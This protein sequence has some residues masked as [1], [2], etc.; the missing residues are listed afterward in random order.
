[1]IILKL[2][3]K[4]LY[5]MNIINI[6]AVNEAELIN[7]YR[8]TFGD[9]ICTIEQIEEV[10]EKCGDNLHEITI[11]SENLSR[12]PKNMGRLNNLRYLHFITKASLDIDNIENC[13][14]LQSLY[15]ESENLTC[16]TNKSFLFKN[17]Q[18]IGL[19]CRGLSN[20][21][22]CIL[23]ENLYT[24]S[25]N[26]MKLESFSEEIITLLV[27]LNNLHINAP[28]KHLGSLRNCRKLCYLNLCGTFLQDVNEVSN[29]P[30]SLISLQLDTNNLLS[31]NI[32]VGHLKNIETLQF[33][34]SNT[35]F[36]PNGI[37]NCKN[38][39]QL[40]L[41][42]ISFL[43]DD[44][45]D[46]N[47][48]ISLTVNGGTMNSLPEWLTHKTQLKGIS[49]AN[50]RL[51]NIPN[52][53]SK[54]TGL[55]GLSIYSNKI[56]DL[57]FV[58]SIPNLKY[59]HAYNN[60]IKDRLFMLDGT[61]IFPGYYSGW[62]E[63]KALHE[64]DIPAFMSAL[65]KSGISREDR[66]WFFYQFSNESKIE[67]PSNWSL[68]RLFQGLTIPHKLLNEKIMKTLLKSEYN[69][70]GLD[71]FKADSICYLDGTFVEKKNTIKDKLESLNIK[72]STTLN[73]I[74]THI[75]IGKKPK[76]ATNVYEVGDMAFLLEHQLYQIIKNI[77]D[78]EKFLVQ[79]EMAG[80]DQMVE[81]VKQLLGSTD[82]NSVH[83]GLQMLKSGGIPS[84]IIE[85]LLLISKTFN[86]SK[87]RAE[88]KKILEVQSPVEW[89]GILKD[90]QTFVDVPTMK[91]KNIRDKFE[92]MT[93][94]IDKR[95]VFL[96]AML[97]SKYYQKGLAFVLANFPLG[98]VER[99]AALKALTVDTHFD[100]H[101]GIGYR[102]W[103]KVSPQEI[104][105]S[106]VN[107]GIPFPIDYPN[108][109]LVRSINM[110]N[111]KFEST[112]KNIDI[113]ENLEELDLSAN[114]LSGVAP[115]LSK[116]TKLKVLDLSSNHLTAFP[117]A[118]A[119][120]TD[121]KKLDLRYNN[122][123]EIQNG[124]RVKITV[125]ENIRE[126]IPTCEILM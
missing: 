81:G 69:S 24:F 37:G 14:G 1:M 66:E 15:F 58:Y 39:K 5:I 36:I 17:L 34:G 97:M 90:K 55:E 104:I 74:V 108:P 3:A 49:I 47:N 10:L 7:E 106:S 41:S 4:L 32:E 120:L 52:D 68:Y 86:D 13:T 22:K 122:L 60:P 126:K 91:E 125:P 102:N 48:L 11:G 40:I 21:P 115:V 119:H 84:G 114:N 112:P 93:N 123:Y 92:K 26:S 82:P 117:K 12:L 85:E 121:L 25:V 62:F 57:N 109:E 28:L 79:E 56:E 46:C 27:G 67:I 77:G 9:N 53:W 103:K 105:H 33:Y 71:S 18:S 23:T 107:T 30:D 87:V 76:E 70:K 124:H 96:F 78:E 50:T 113:F 116:L 19:N 83:I 110:H 99:V 75:I 16:S 20:I 100:F 72:V 45:Q 80:E 73:D 65:G 42:N 111:C 6:K 35:E 63:F 59:V 54:M 98:S 64:K 61:K 118:I 101:R 51:K 31:G 2:L 38:L 29:F 8:L 44:L 88:A 43:P 89:I 95:Q 94:S